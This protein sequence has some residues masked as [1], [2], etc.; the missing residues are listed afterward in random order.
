V[1]LTLLAAGLL[2]FPPLADAPKPALEVPFND[3]FVRDGRLVI[4]GKDFQATAD[5]VNV[6]PD[7]KRVLLIGKDNPVELVIRMK[8]QP[9]NRFVGKKILLNPSE[10]TLRIEG[11]GLVE[12]REK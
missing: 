1:V 3:V 9:A 2:S 7:G 8:G 12:V 4:G 6:S 11:A 10:G 5:R